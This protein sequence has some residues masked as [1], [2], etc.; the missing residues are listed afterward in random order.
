MNTKQKIISK[1]FNETALNEEEIIHLAKNI[2]TKKTPYYPEIKQGIGDDGALIRF[3]ND[4]YVITTDLLIEGIHFDL[5]IMSPAD[6]GWRTMAANLSDLA[7]M[8]ALPCWGFLSL[9]LNPPIQVELVQGLL[10]GLI[11]LGTQHRLVLAGGDTVRST[12][13]LL[14]LCLIG[15]MQGIRPAL[16]KNAQPGDLICITGLL[17]LSA[18]GLAW[19]QQVKA[20]QT[21][22]SI[23]TS[24]VKAYRRPIPRLAAGRALT[25]SG[26]ITAMIDI[27]DGIASDLTRLALASGTG[28][29]LIENWL[30]FDPALVRIAKKLDFNPLS[31]ILNGGEDFELLFTC[32]PKAINKLTNLVK[33]A[34]ANLTIKVVGKITTDPGIWL[35]TTNGKYHDITFKGYNHFR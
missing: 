16:R 28:A 29:I 27:S 4:D 35:K 32:S 18:S 15:A 20:D 11:N 3:K 30:P 31:W 8:G 9:G 5:T 19:L 10:E 24:L 6:V 25:A 22:N 17:G 26:L 21:N 33:N 34:E 13:M 12:N 1:T 14:N 23:A 2:V 7:A